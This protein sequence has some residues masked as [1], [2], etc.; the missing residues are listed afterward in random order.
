MIILFSLCQIFWPTWSTNKFIVS[1][2]FR[3]NLINRGIIFILIMQIWTGLKCQTEFL[4]LLFLA[5]KEDRNAREWA[6]EK[7]EEGQ[8]RDWKWFNQ[9]DFFLKFI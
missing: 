1:Y 9:N 3:Q 5:F 7:R 2:V 6:F 8:E 4:A